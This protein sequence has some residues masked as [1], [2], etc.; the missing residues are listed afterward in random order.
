MSEE[1]FITFEEIE[2][3]L[4]KIKEPNWRH[5]YFDRFPK[6]LEIYFDELL[7][8]LQINFKY[9]LMGIDYEFGIRHS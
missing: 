4:L 3:A 6:I 7:L 5:I 1:I 2:E 9:F 8:T